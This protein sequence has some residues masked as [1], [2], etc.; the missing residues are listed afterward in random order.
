MEIDRIFFKI[1]INLNTVS[2]DLYSKVHRL[3][4]IIDILWSNIGIILHFF[5]FFFYLILLSFCY[6][7]LFLAS[8]FLTSDWIRKYPFLSVRIS[9]PFI[10][11]RDMLQFFLLLK[12]FQS[13][14][15]VHF[16]SSSVG[17]GISFNT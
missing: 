3:T 15:R 4:C 12:G 10:T 8:I 2:L 5:F 9:T 16:S 14:L 13:F 11:M 1:R 7:K 17:G 6:M